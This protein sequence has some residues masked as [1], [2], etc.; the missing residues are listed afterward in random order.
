LGEIGIGNLALHAVPQ[1]GRRT[2]PGWGWPTR[3]GFGVKTRC[4]PLT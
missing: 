1:N 2:A 3:G 4:A